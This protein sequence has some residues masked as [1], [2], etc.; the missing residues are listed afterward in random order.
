MSAE[1]KLVIEIGTYVVAEENS[2]EMEVR[3][4]SG[5]IIASNKYFRNAAV[6]QEVVDIIKDI[7]HNCPL[8]PQCGPSTSHDDPRDHSRNRV[9]THGLK[10]GAEECLLPGRKIV[11]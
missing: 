10:A 5:R 2:L 8:N 4:A 9:T 3:P 1:V 7:C 11:I 6:A